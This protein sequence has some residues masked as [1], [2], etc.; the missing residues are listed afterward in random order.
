[1]TDVLMSAVRNLTRIPGVRGVLII[2]AE[3]GIPVAGDMAVAASENALAALTDALLRRAAEAMAS[4]GRGR[5]RSLQLDATEGTL[6]VAGAG[7]LLV[8]VLASPTAQIGLVRV[9]TARTAEELG[10]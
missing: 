2:D 7:P 10:R 4:T 3:A 8:A 9:Q 5:L 1:M 6:V